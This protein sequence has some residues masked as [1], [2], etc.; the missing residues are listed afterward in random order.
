M[1]PERLL[2]GG[3]SAP[4]SRTRSNSG[5]LILLSG[6][7]TPA[8]LRRLGRKRLA[9]WLRNLKVHSPEDLT[10]AALEAAER[11]HTA[12]PGEKITAQVIQ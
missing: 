2:E 6:Y 8:A 4:S 10:E 5:P 11:Q 9:T 3:R 7:Q 1:E 12:V